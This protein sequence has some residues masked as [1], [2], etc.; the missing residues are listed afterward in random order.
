MSYDATSHYLD[1]TDS[2]YVRTRRERDK[3]REQ[4]DRMR[5]ALTAIAVRRCLSEGPCAP[6][7]HPQCV[8]SCVTCLARA[9]LE[10]S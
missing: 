5:A 9:A 7:G 3:A 1:T 6:H 10:E 4:A 2:C 8:G